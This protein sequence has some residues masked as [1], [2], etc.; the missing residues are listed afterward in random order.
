MS[1]L[2]M[3]LYGSST[4]NRIVGMASGLDTDTLVEQM[5]AGTKNK[6]NRAY[7]SKQKLLYR[8]EAYREISTKLVAFSDKYLSFSSSKSTNILSNSFFD[9]STIKSSSDYVSV[10]GNSDSIKNFKITNVASVAT[11]ASFTSTST[12]SNNIIST[13]GISSAD[14]AVKSTSDIT[15]DFNGVKK[16][17]NLYDASGVTNA[18]KLQ[19]KLDNAFGK[20]KI[21]VNVD[22]NNNFITGFETG[23]AV[24]KDTDV[25]GITDIN[26]VTLG[27]TEGTYNRISKSTAIVDSGIK[28]PLNVGTDGKYHITIN[29]EKFTFETTD[30]LNDIISEIN[31]NSNAGVT[32]YY[33]SV[34]DKITV[35]SDDTGLGSRINISDDAD[36]GSLSASLFGPLPVNTNGTDTEI[37][38]SLNGVDN[39]TIRRSTSSFAIDDINID[40][41]QNA[42]GNII[43]SDPT[44]ATT[45]NVTKNTDD[46]IKNVKQFIDDYNEIISLISKKTTERPNRDFQPLT[47]D[48]QDE[49]EKDDIDSW[50]EQAKKG[51]L[52]GDSKMDNVLRNLRNVM[53]NKTSVSTLTLS[54]IGIAPASYDTSGKLVFNEE[55]FKTKLNENPEEVINLFTKSATETNGVS[56]IAKQVQSILQANVG[57]FGG[58]GTLIEEAGLSDGLTADKNFLSKSMAEYDKKM[59]KLKDDLADEKERYYKKF[60]A[61]EQALN[62]LNNQSSWLTSMMSQ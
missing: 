62:S 59:A 11:N 22:A 5:A 9:S 12:I 34:T 21:K 51:M 41:N 36:G 37:T 42:V 13:S 10:S 15:I 46:I 56:G 39:L 55:T 14:I 30:S 29:D 4:S 35:K 16:T 28:G 38:Y 17:I 54:S 1:I 32:M 33:S 44:T 31:N 27:V 52:Y 50:N 40:L 3:N 49:M 6:I 57:T 53:S 18:T 48:Q 25:F 20:D 58:T 26:D 43:S 7:Q 60:T 19:A 8:Q 45:F 24:S 2:S 47:P 61:L 23:D